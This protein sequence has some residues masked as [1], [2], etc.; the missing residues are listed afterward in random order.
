MKN[1]SLLSGLFA[2]F[3]SVALLLPSIGG[4]VQAQENDPSAN[5]LA[6]MENMTP[7][8]RVG[9]LFLISFD[10]TSVSE[11]TQIAALLD[12]YSVGG[13]VL[14]ADRENFAVDS[15]SGLQQLLSDLQRK[16]IMHEL[17]KR[18]EKMG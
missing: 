2:L 4:H 11:E 12:Q 7:E 15:L 13:I 18:L 1:N 3:L 14:R 8:E 9:Q 10:G 17:P 5:V 6:L 16:I